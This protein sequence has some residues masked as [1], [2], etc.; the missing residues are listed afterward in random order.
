MS[1]GRSWKI[2][3][4]NQRLKNRTTKKMHFK[5]E[6]KTFIHVHAEIIVAFPEHCSPTIMVRIFSNVL[7]FYQIFL[8]T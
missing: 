8:L 1:W 4:K 3:I 7:M 6:K 5:K 2:E